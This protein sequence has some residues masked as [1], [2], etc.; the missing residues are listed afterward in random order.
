GTIDS[1][2]SNA[3]V[4]APSVSGLDAGAAPATPLPPAQPAP[5]APFAPV[6]TSISN[7]AS[8]QQPI[9]APTSAV[10]TTAGLSDGGDLAGRVGARGMQIMSSAADTA[11]W[12]G[13][14]GVKALQS[15]LM[16]EGGLAGARG[17]SGKSAGPLQF[18][19]G[20][21]LATF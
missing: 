10:Q 3:A 11:S 1:G 8:T 19:E 20:G 2:P 9:T 7:P 14:Q 15:V 17:D 4:E 18:Y 16:T 13:D 5:P 12:L 6:T 21:Q